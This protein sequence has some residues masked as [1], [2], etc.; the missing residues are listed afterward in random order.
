[1]LET[2]AASNP[3]DSERVDSIRRNSAAHV[4]AWKRI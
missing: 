3:A 2:S 4:T 1:M